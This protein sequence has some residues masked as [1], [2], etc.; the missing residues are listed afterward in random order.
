M[1]SIIILIL[2]LW[3]FIPGNAVF[4]ADET[5]KIEDYSYKEGLTTSGINSV[6]RDSKGFLWICSKNGLFRFDGYSFRNINTLVKDDINFEVNCITEDADHNFFIGAVNGIIYYNTHTQRI[7]P[8]KLNLINHFSINKILLFQDKIWAASTAGL[9]MIHSPETIDSAIVYQARLL[10]PDPLHKRTPQDNII[11]T[12]Y[13]LPG[14]PSLWV[15]TNGALFELN[16]QTLVFQYINSFSQES[17]RG[18]AKYNNQ[19]IVSSWDRGVFLVNP[20][21]HKFENDAF[22]NEVNRVIGNQRTMYAINDNQN[23]LWVATYGKGLYI[24]EKDNRGGASFVNYRN[25]Q[26]KRENLKSDFIFQMY[27]DNDGIAWLSTSLPTLSKVY[28]QKSNFSYVNFSNQKNGTS[29]EIY[30]VNQSADKDK[31]WIT[32]NGGGMYLFD[33]KKNSYSQF[34]DNTVTGLRLQSNEPSICH[35]DKKGNLWIVYRRMGLYV[36][37]AKTALGL[38]DGSVRT[39]VKPLDANNLITHS[40]ALNSY[41][42]TFYDDSQGRLWVGGW[43]SLY[44]VELN[45]DASVTDNIISG[46]KTTCIYSDI[47]KDAVNFPIS[48]VFSIVEIKKNQFWLGTLGAGVVQLDEVS[49]NKFSGKQ[50][51]LNKQLVTNNVK[52]IY[53]DSKNNI[54]IGTNSGLAC[55]DSKTG[56]FKRITAKDGLSSDNVNN[57]IEDRNSDIWVSTS[58]GISEIKSSDFSIQNYF[59][60]D[61]E[62]YNQ[63]IPYA[64]SISSGGLLCFSTNETLVMINPDSVKLEKPNTPLYFTDIKI[65]NKTVVPLISYNGTRVID[66]SINECNAINVPYNHTLSLEFAALDYFLPERIAYKYKIGKNSEW[67]LLS[68]GQRNLTLP[69]LSHGEYTLS[70][71]VAN[72]NGKNNVRSV[73]INYLP[74][75]WLSRAAFLI[76]SA[77]VLILLFTYRKLIIQ[78]TLQKSLVEKERY[79]RKKI[80]ELDKMK[81]EFFSN[82]SHEFRTPLSLIINPLEKL[83]SEGNISAKDKERVKLILKSSNRLLKLTN[84]LMDFSKI[85]KELMK[86]DFQLCEIVSFTNDICRLFN[87]LADSMNIDFKVNNSFDRLEIPIDKGMVEKIIFNLLSNAFKYTSLNG[88][89]MVNLSKINEDEKEYIKLSVINTGEGISKENLNHVFDRYYQ[90]NNVQNRNAEGTGIGLSLVK[91]FVELHN[92]KAEVKSDPN[93]ET[94]FDILLPAIQPD[95]KITGDFPV[96]PLRSVKTS[97][98]LQD[99]EQVPAKHYRVLIVEDEEDIKN[100]I[101]EELSVEYKVLTAKNGEEGLN[102]A[103]ETIPDLI[104]TDVIMPVLSG[105]EMC[106]QL[107]NQMITSHIPIIILSAKTSVPQQIEGLEM[108]ADV[109]M[110]KPFNVDILKVQIQ[111]LINLKQTIYS[112]FLKETTLIPQDAVTNGL[113]DDFMKRALTFIEENL[114]NSNLNVD[115]LANCVYLSKVQTY[116]KI[117]AISGLSIVEFIRTVR[118]K[119]AAQLVLEGRLNFSEIAFETGFSSPSYFSKCFHDHFGK[120]PSEFAIEFGNS[121]ESAAS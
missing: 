63:Y 83:I 1:K 4:A 53:K 76:Y 120:T 112:K 32:T 81:S 66:V 10:M 110:V 51:E 49:R 23:H 105:I 34:T 39:T 3:L 65:D 31:L 27:L 7:F 35:Q 37:P 42:T 95:F 21:K 43:G 111:R 30:A 102:I 90:V 101:V 78:K 68:P 12:I 117:K 71:M 9:L 94:S 57:I 92:G 22:I 29:K 121:K 25:D 70:I 72:T 119:K 44:V 6:Y 80:E 84:E 16:I 89:I 61:N 62:K 107:K 104:I 19:I 15:G 85:E 13:Y 20:S 113:D 40:S 2:S 54:W 87:N 36:L 46:S 5:I 82:I 45:H 114:T 100:Y 96:I 41:I 115:Q 77:I 28:F 97:K 48:P 38:L 55:G 58:Y 75:F 14:N 67:I 18:I 52:S 59:Y 11:N 26:T 91:S 60:T 79:E 17:I 64:A 47:R 108:G 73:N 106:K 56:S 50:L 33:I 93:L 98:P 88:F 99:N 74:P 116:R 103:N 24:F 86:P 109:Y 118:L 69:N 8:L